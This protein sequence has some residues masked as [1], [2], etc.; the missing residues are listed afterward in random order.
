MKATPRYRKHIHHCTICGTRVD[1]KTTIWYRGGR[2]HSLC[3][4]SRF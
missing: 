2:V 4:R 3:Y 1:E